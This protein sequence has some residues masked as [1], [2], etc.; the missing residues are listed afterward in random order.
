[1]MKAGDVVKHLPSGETW[2]LIGVDSRPERRHVYPGGWPASRGNIDDCEFIEH[3]AD[4]MTEDIV[5]IRRRMWPGI[6][7]DA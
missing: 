3:R 2:L 4:F 7:F 5:E 6:Q 1:M